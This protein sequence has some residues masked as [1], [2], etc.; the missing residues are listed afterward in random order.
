MRWI[1]THDKTKGVEGLMG[2]Y[3]SEFQAQ[4]VADK[5]EVDYDIIYLPTSDPTRATRLV[6]EQKIQ[7]EGYE[8]GTK[9]MVHPKNPEDS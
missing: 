6:K 9:R 2:P 4:K 8:I 1:T 5:L 7:E 3:R